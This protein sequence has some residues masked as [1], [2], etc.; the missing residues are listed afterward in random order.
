MALA[1][2]ASAVRLTVWAV[3][4]AAAPLVPGLTA[5]AGFEDARWPTCNGAQPCS[6][7]ARIAALDRHR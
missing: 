7:L 3:G 4:S 6:G 2:A 5:S 1:W